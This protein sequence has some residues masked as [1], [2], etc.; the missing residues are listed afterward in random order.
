MSEP[1]PSAVWIRHPPSGQLQQVSQ[2]AWEA[3]QEAAGLDPDAEGP[4][5][6]WQL[7]TAAQAAQG[8][9]VKAD[10]LARLGKAP[11]V[12]PEPEPA[13]VEPTGPTRRR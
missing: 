7:A 2:A 8:E 6:R 3:A 13:E 5:H 1:K 10:K 12:D 9:Q 11:K 4:F